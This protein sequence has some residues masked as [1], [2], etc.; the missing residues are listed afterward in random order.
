MSPHRPR[1]DTVQNSWLNKSL[2]DRIQILRT[3]APAKVEGL[4]ILVDEALKDEM[5]DARRLH[6][7][8]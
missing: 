5:E 4:S 3:V 2:E 1:P 8:T 7:E 6:A